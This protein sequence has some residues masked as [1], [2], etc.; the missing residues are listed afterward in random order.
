MRVY[1]AHDE[2]LEGSASH[3]GHRFSARL[4]V[5]PCSGTL[6]DAAFRVDSPP[7]FG[8]PCVQVPVVHPS[9]A[10]ASIGRIDVSMYVD[11]RNAAWS[12]LPGSTRAAHF[13]RAPPP[14]PLRKAQASSIMIV[15]VMIAGRMMM[16]GA[17]ARASTPLAARAREC[18]MLHTHPT[19]AHT[20]TLGHTV[21]P[22]VIVC[23]RKTLC[24]C[25]RVLIWQVNLFFARTT[26]VLQQQIPRL[27]QVHISKSNGPWSVCR[28]GWG[29][30][31]LWCACVRFATRYCPVSNKSATRLFFPAG[32]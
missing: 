25:A 5:A 14:L 19:S 32:G 11:A 2:A 16:M 13:E 4:V 1:A 10:F 6:G 3:T 28:P 27:V 29:C 15:I 9:R 7:A 23:E 30:S 24:V 31:R 20:Y 12:L 21:R 18:E 26:Y 17:A 8:T 22:P